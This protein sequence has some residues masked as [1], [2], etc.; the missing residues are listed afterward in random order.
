MPLRSAGMMLLA[1]SPRPLH[2]CFTQLGSLDP[3]D[4]PIVALGE[5]AERANLVRSPGV[6]SAQIPD[7]SPPLAGTPIL[8]DLS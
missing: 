4:Q 7:L 3:W 6:A 1:V 8:I 5:G 2:P